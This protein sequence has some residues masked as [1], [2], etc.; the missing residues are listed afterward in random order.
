MK[1]HKNGVVKQIKDSEK[2]AL[3]THCYSHS[4]NLA[5]GDTMKSVKILKDTI[6]T[7]FELT[8]LV[9][10]SP[11]RDSKLKII[12]N[13][14]LRD[15]H[16]KNDD[17]E[18]DEIFHKIKATITLFCPTRW[19]VRG[20]CLNG[21]IENY[22]ELQE[23]WEWSLDNVSD[24]EMKARIRGVKSHTKEFAYCFGIHMAETLL[25]IT[26]NLSKTLQGT[27]HTAV[28][29]Q[30]NA[31]DSV[32]TLQSI[33]DDAHFSLFYAKVEK[34]SKEHDVGGPKLSRK[35]NPSQKTI[36]SCYMESGTSTPHHPLTPE[37]DYRQKYFECVDLIIQCINDRFDQEDFRMYASCE[38]LLL[39]SLRKEDYSAELTTVTEFYGN[40]FS[41]A[42]LDTQLRSLPFV[43]SNITDASMMHS[44]MF[45]REFK[46]FQV[47]RKHLSPRS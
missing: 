25:R 3:Y 12:K 27:Q 11:K 33:R 31:R 1:G 6:D 14:I 28:E 40:D 23:L 9:K 13:E 10:K 21:V 41:I 43:L 35:R 37:D 22:D 45:G 26:D 5:V 36:E 24:S 7:T 47:A 17:E 30:K 42:V 44:M 18:N 2:R 15:E 16:D 34:F 39:K 8:K 32:A 20:K 38:Q 19:T 4:L 46:N 29:A